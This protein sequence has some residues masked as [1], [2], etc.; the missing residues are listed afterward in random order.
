M[1]WKPSQHRVLPSMPIP[2]TVLLA[3]SVVASAQDLPQPVTLNATARVVLIPV[4]VTDRKGKFIDGLSLDD[5]VVADEGIRQ[6]I[7]MDTSDT[8]VAPV[9]LVVAIQ[10]SGISAAVLAKIEKVG[11]MIQ[12]LVIGDKGKAAVIAFDDEVRVF[13]DFTSDGTNIR[14]AFERV[15]GRVIKKAHLL[16]AASEAIAMLQTRPENSRRIL[17]I[18]S[19]SRDRGS[20]AK[21]LDVI[22]QAQRA[23]VMIYPA[24]Y[25]AHATPWTARSEDNPPMPGGAYNEVDF[26]GP[27]IELLRLGKANAADAFAGATGGRHLSFTTLQGLEETIARAGEDIH[28]QY[29]LSF[30]PNNSLPGA[31]GAFHKLVVT[32]P[33]QGDAVVR[34]RPG[35]WAR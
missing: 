9:S 33:S 32:V 12:P 25:S 3:L 17:L 30:V 7:R 31:N 18:L 29:L 15:H 21:L 11:A 1:V 20:K 13:Q 26:I 16:D 8:V 4:A 19:E 23:G 27:A 24:T 10:C 5:F 2:V 35:Y 34:A 28:S 22:Q 14:K 6:R